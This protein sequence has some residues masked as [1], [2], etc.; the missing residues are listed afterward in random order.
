MN[1]KSIENLAVTNVS[2]ELDMFELQA[3]KDQVEA[4][5]KHY[6]HVDKP[7]DERESS[8]TYITNAD[9]LQILAHYH[10]FFKKIT[11]DVP[12]RKEVWSGLFG[13]VKPAK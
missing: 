9:R 6:E 12:S 5:D 4:L 13:E 10:N 1:I 2:I 3:I 7:R 11:G 8:K